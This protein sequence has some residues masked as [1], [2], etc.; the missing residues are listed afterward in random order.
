MHLLHKAKIPYI[1]E[2][3]EYVI[4]AKTVICTKY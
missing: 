2:R 3:R 4:S 1:L